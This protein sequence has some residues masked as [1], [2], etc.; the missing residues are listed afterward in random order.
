MI[1]LMEE[2]EADVLGVRAHGTLTSSDYRQVLAPR[3]ESMLERFGT[4][5][6][7]VLM[8]ETFKGW[9]LAGAWANTS[10]DIRHRADFE[11][12][13]VVGAPTWEEWCVKLA[14]LLIAGEVR[15]FPADRLQD[16]WE[17]LRS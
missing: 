1:E 16:A 6:V 8:D 11:R 4:V 15:T 9:D 17:W 14:G 12:V 2:S 5:R 7:L 3:L 13:A 10:M